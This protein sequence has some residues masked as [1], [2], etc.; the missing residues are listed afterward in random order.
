M[1]QLFTGSLNQLHRFALKEAIKRINHSG[2]HRRD[3]SVIVG[4]STVLT[5]W[6]DLLSD[7]IKIVYFTGFGRLFTDYSVAGRI[8]FYILLKILWLCNVHAIIVENKDDKNLISKYIPTEVYLVPGSG[9]LSKFFYK[10]PKKY[11]EDGQIIFGYLSRFGP[12]KHTDEILKLA[13]KLPKH[14]KLVIAGYDISAPKFSQEFENIAKIKNNVEF[15]GQLYQPRQVS[16][17]FNSINCLIYPS[18]REGLPLTIIE[19]A[20]HGV[21]FITTDVPGCR[22]VATTLPGLTLAANSFSNAEKLVDAFG[23]IKNQETKNSLSDYDFD[24]VSQHFERIIR[25][26]MSSNE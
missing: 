20:W 5:H 1:I 2:N 16:D 15:L 25:N 24:N 22:Q 8:A 17:F 23:K 26:V 13:K 14:L 18:K 3:L 10:T 6:R 12:S 19:A 9:F 21:K 11:V 4:T 7:N